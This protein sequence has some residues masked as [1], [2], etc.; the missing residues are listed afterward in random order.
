MTQED[1]YMLWAAVL[2]IV[3]FVWC[4]L[5]AGSNTSIT[6]RQ[7]DHDATMAAEDDDAA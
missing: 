3:L 6:I 2:A 1:V 7:S 4:C 5:E